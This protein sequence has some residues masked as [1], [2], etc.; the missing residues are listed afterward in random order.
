MMRTICSVLCCL[1]ISP[2]TSRSCV[3]CKDQATGGVRI[4]HYHYLLAA[5]CLRY[6][7]T[8]PPGMACLSYTHCGNCVCFDICQPPL[9][10]DR[11]ATDPKKI[12]KDAKLWHRSKILAKQKLLQMEKAEVLRKEK[13]AKEVERKKIA[14]EEAKR[15]QA[16]MKDDIDQ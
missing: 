10:F 15:A 16:L 8:G 7:D 9:H 14:K 3:S 4:I 6:A 5:P 13:V 12:C 1:L 11:H 2:V